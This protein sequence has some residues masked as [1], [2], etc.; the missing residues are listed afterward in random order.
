MRIVKNIVLTSILLS[1]TIEADPLSNQAMDH[2]GTFYGFLEQCYSRAIIPRTNIHNDNWKA[3]EARGLSMLD[4][5][6]RQ[7]QMGSQGRA[8]ELGSGQWKTYE[9]NRGYCKFVEGEQK[10][11]AISISR[12]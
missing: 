1:P 3:L 11:L 9:F 2:I 5:A 10:K 4:L 6:S 7:S 8:F 12:N